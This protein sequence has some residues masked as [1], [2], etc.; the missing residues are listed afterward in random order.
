MLL[1]WYPH[2]YIVTLDLGQLINFPSLQINAKTK[3][4]L[5]PTIQELPKYQDQINPVVTSVLNIAVIILITVIFINQST[6]Y[7]LPNYIC[8]FIF[9][10]AMSFITLIHNI[11]Q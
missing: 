5:S 9:K 1:K 2:L 11:N 8:K 7:K 10:H 3:Y 4:Q 6:M